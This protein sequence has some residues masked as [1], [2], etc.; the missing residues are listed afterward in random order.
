MLR[1]E[2]NEVRNE[3][4]RTTEIA[5]P[6]IS[7]EKERIG[8]VAEAK[9]HEW[10]VHARVDYTYFDQ[11][12]ATFANSFRNRAKRPDYLI[13]LKDLGKI[14]VDVKSRAFQKEFE[15]FILDEEE[16]RKLAS[17]QEISRI[18]VWFAISCEGIGHNTWYWIS[19]NYI[20]ANIKQMVSRKSFKPFRPVGIRECVTIGWNDSLE[21]LFS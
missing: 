16:I 19:L 12:L 10:L 15:T 8:R 4:I 17:F 18:S 6:K 2:T 3:R 20:L 13:F 1:Q 9:F 21:K 11:S 14:A 5:F 7:D